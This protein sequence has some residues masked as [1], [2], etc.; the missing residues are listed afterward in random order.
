MNIA[1]G[2]L[3][4]S[5]NAERFDRFTR[6]V[7]KEFGVLLNGSK[8]SMVETRLRRRLN[9]LGMPDLDTYLAYLFE[10]KNLA[11]EHGAI[12]NAITTNKTDFYREPAHYDH[13][14][15]AAIPAAIDRA[16]RAGRMVKVWSAAASTGA[17]AW[18]A[19]FCL[20][21]EARK[22]PFNWG[23]VGTD[24][25]TDVLETA[26]RAIYQDN[27]LTPVPPPV[28]KR[29]LVPGQGQY[30]GQ[31]RVAPELRKRVKFA[32]LNLLERGVRFE[33][34]IDIIFL[35]N[36]LIYFSPED[37]ERAIQFMIQ[38][39]AIGGYLYLGHS[40]T[41]SLNDSRMVTE[42]P[43]VFRKTS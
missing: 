29:W 5:L 32:H 4:D 39:L 8:K 33:H 22:K 19:A 20:A 15:S 31:S 3:G 25:N 14:T 34:G 23:I 7:Q 41:M 18:T 27:L 42:Q 12:V 13:M 43:A 40:E 24:I 17:E 11:A 21:E 37:Q 16:N 2:S 28:R 6:H 36:V 26:S 9:E 1:V 38:H 30:R 10:G 35:R